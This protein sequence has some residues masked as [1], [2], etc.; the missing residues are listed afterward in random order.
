M[1]NYELKI[2][3]VPIPTYRRYAV[4]SPLDVLLDSLVDGNACRFCVPPEMDAKKI[5]YALIAR[6]LRRGFNIKTQILEDA[7]IF[8][9]R[10]EGA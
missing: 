5:R 6:A 2:E 8:W 1:K 10:A 3:Q 4:H 7:I 9:K